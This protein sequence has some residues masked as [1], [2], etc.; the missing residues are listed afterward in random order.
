MVIPKSVN[1]KRIAENFKATQVILDA[2][3]VK[4]L[5]DIDKDTRLFR[6]NLINYVVVLF[7]WIVQIHV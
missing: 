7:Q 5:R 6:V 2:E 3:E 4:R 1:P